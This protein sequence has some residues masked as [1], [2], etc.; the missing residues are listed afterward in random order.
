[1]ITAVGFPALPNL[2]PSEAPSAVL[3]YAARLAH[4]FSKKIENLVAR[5]P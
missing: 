2:L 5:T 1:M 4:G 3:A